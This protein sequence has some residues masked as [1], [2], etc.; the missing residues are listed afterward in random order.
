MIIKMKKNNT[1]RFMVMAFFTFIVLALAWPLSMKITFG[2][3]EPTYSLSNR[4]L[5][6]LTAQNQSA[7]IQPKSKPLFEIKFI[8]QSSIRKSII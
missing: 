1:K 5:L 3:C 2:V 7:A 4:K 6:S 8:F